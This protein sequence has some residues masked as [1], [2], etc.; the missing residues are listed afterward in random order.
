MAT[1]DV[2]SVAGPS[3]GNNHMM[4]MTSQLHLSSSPQQLQPAVTAVCLPVSVQQLT[5][6]DGDFYDGSDG[7]GNDAVD[8]KT[9]EGDLSLKVSSSTLYS[10][11]L[12]E[13]QIHTRSVSHRYLDRSSHVT[14]FQIY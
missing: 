4:P 6:D 7:D 3:L 8:N 13:F 9:T 12:A 1:D 11:R 14:H 5:Y 2:P 10:E